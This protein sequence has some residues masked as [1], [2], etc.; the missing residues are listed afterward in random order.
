MDEE[1]PGILLFNYLQISIFR[2]FTI[3]LLVKGKDFASVKVVENVDT[4]TY[5][6]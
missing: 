5:F 2:T 3:T 1:S 6:S 4:C